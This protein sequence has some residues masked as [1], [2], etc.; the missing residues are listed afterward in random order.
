MNLFIIRHAESA[1]NRIASQVDY[2]TFV[3][4]REFDPPITDVGHLQSSQLA[5][6]LASSEHPEFGRKSA[7]AKQ[8][9]YGITHLYCSPMRRSLQT[10][11]PVSQ[12]LGLPLVVWS[13]IHEQGGLFQGNPHT[14]EGLHGSPGLTRSEMVRQFPGV[15]LPDEITEEGWWPGHYEDM[16]ECDARAERVARRLFSLADHETHARIAIVSHGTFI[17][18][19]L[20][21]LFGPAGERPMY[22]SHANTGITRIEFTDDSYLVLRYLN[23]LQHLPAEMVTR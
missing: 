13:D 19:L 22:F 8:I 5:Q 10:A 23:R 6:H 12:A 7:E 1:N 3:A 11:L 16:H 2:D 21:R 20:K 14:G 4:T 17:D 18:H 15:Q 9:G